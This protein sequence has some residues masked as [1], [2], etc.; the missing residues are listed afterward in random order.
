M[1]WARVS[2]ARLV[3]EIPQAVDVSKA[4]PRHATPVERIS[5]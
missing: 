3:R 4:G 1:E 2:E 5:F